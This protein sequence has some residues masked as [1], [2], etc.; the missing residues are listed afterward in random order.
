MKWPE[1]FDK[2]L[3]N[4]NNGHTY[5]R[6]WK[7]FFSETAMKEIYN[8]CSLPPFTARMDGARE[9]ICYAS[10]IVLLGYDDY[11]VGEGRD[12]E[13]LKKIHSI[14]LDQ[15]GDS[16]I[17]PEDLFYAILKAEKEITEWLCEKRYQDDDC[18]Y[19]KQSKKA[20]PFL[21]K[22]ANQW[23]DQADVNHPNPLWLSLWFERE[24]C[25]LFAESNVGK[26]IYAVQMACEIAR[27][28]KVLYVDY[29]MDEP[30]FRSRYSD[31]KGNPFSFPEN[32]LRAQL[33][34]DNFSGKKLYYSL[35]KDL[36]FIIAKNNI[37]I[38]IIDN[39]TFLTEGDNS[40]VTVA[41]I[42]KMLKKLRDK[43]NLSILIISHAKRRDLTTP[44]SHVDLFA[45]PRFF[46]LI[47][48]C[49]AL[50]KSEKKKD[51]C[52]LKQIK[53]RNSEIEFGTENVMLLKKEKSDAFISFKQIGVDDE[54]NHLQNKRIDNNEWLRKKA[55]LLQSQNLSYAQIAD[56][57]LISKAKAFRL[58]NQ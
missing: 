1:K 25:S 29:E 6:F 53:A 41:R 57:L 19:H 5:L 15:Y 54:R 56:T 23:V 22:E 49:F 30:I 7:C 28:K 51:L 42:M 3:I 47:D 13:T 52:Y 50:V 48:S 4:D 14:I 40:G 37:E 31:E 36:D 18:G 58:L 2:L 43:H 12:I 21:V 35:L 45:N 17:F 55:A 46:H 20:P 39:L 34:P 27:L 8:N 9:V 32:F 44:V 33:N 38:L 16:D 10:K 24:I 11:P 26:S